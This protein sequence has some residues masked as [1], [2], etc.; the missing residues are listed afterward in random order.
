MA[1]T[2]K[3]FPVRSLAAELDGQ[4]PRG[5]SSAANDLTPL[6]RTRMCVWTSSVSEEA[7]DRRARTR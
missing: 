5:A 7:D 4:R 1:N 2:S 6:Y 3:V